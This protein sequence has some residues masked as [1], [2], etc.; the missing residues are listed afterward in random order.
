[1]ELRERLVRATQ[2]KGVKTALAT[3]LNVTPGAISQWLSG[4]TMPDAEK[5]LRLLDWVREAEETKQNSPGGA[6]T[7]P[8]PKT[9]RRKNR[10]EPTQS[11]P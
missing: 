9:Q 1:M 11:G 8:E 6:D 2:A 5:T 7:P 10:N 3:R 4:K